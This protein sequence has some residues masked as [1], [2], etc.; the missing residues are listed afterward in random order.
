MNDLQLNA[1]DS[2][3]LGSSGLPWISP[4]LAGAKLWPVSC[5]RTWQQLTSGGFS[6]QAV[7][8]N[9]HSSAIET[10]VSTWRRVCVF[11]DLCISSVL[12]SWTNI[13]VFATDWRKICKRDSKRTSQPFIL[14]R[15]AEN[16]SFWRHHVILLVKSVSLPCGGKFEF[17]HLPWSIMSARAIREATGKRL[18]NQ[19]LVNAG[20]AQCRWGYP[21]PFQREILV[22]FMKVV[23][24]WAMISYLTHQ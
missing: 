2:S 14:E 9:R 11:V 13:S 22:P 4:S 16:P 6:V 21:D 19:N 20:A 15:K 5:L 8:T 24:C 3:L 18:L 10:S 7:V 1:K 12:W 23:C 17:W